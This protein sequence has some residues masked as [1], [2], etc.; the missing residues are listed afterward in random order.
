MGPELLSPTMSPPREPPLQRICA[1]R[2]PVTLPTNPEQ[3]RSMERHLSSP[4]FPPPE[5]TRVGGSE[6]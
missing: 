6:P 5:S 3:D 1:A 2:S 4:P